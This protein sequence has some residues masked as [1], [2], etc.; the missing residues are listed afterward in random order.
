MSPSSTM[1]DFPLTI[2]HIFR[3]GLIHRKSRIATWSPDD[4]EML[5]FGDV[6]GHIGQLANLLARIGIRQGDVVGTL[7]WNHH[8]HFAAY[9]AVPAM[10]AILHT[11]NLRLGPDQLGH[12]I[13]HGGAKAI[14]VD[15][16]LLPL[17]APLV[18]GLPA[19]T[20]V[21]VVDAKGHVDPLPGVEIISDFDAAV[22]S[23]NAHYPWPDID[24]RAA[25]CMCYTSGT[26][27]NAKGVVYSHRSQVLHAFSIN[28]AANFALTERDRIL[29]IVPL[30]HANA[31]GTPYAGWWAGSDFILPQQ[32]LQA[33]HLVDMIETQ[34]PT[35]AAGV[36]TIWNDLLVY[37]EGRDIDLSSLR[38]VISGGS[39]VPRALI[40]RFQ[41][42]FGIPMTQGWG[43]TECSP[44]AALAV[45]PADASPEVE[46]D[47]R[48]YSGRIIPGIEMRLVD[49]DGR[50]QPHNGE[51]MG[52]IQVRGAWVTGGYHA[53]EGASSFAEG[54]LRTGDVGIITDDGYVKLVDRAKD[55]IKSGGEWISSVT[56]ENLLVEH[57]AVAEAAVIAIA[58]ERWGERPLPCVVLREGVQCS[59][60]ELQA[61]L[62]SRLPRWWLPD[63]WAIVDRLP[64]TSVGK[65]DKKLLR[66]EHADGMWPVIELAGD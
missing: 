15:A 17:L 21:I 7:A 26:T 3:H 34:R 8:Q 37:A 22:A 54:W 42:R 29:M 25:A 65:Y 20:H 44:L 13:A 12:I 31:W 16:S 39:A 63:R 35:F 51:A 46:L 2:G 49:D 6:A 10:G 43:M 5:S 1:M 33:P 56:I 19:L 66:A 9:F 52:E 38:D 27:G 62:A 4:V 45:P 58:D 24:E 60:A 48:A 36:P 14:I 50:I 53:G 23:E 41:Q 57:Q 55:V 11:L 61:W 47:Y 28:S 18:E 59:P 64:R 30:F 32:Y 40:E